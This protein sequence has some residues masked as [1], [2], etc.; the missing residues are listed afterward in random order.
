MLAYKTNFKKF[1]EIKIMQSMFSD[2]YKI[3]LQNH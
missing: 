1:K 2:H 3:K